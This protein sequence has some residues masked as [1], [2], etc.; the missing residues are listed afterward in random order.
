MKLTCSSSFQSKM[1]GTGQRLG[2]DQNGWPE[3]VTESLGKLYNSCWI[4]LVNRFSNSR[5]AQMIH[6]SKTSG[7]A[8]TRKLCRVCRI[9][10][11]FPELLSV[12]SR[13][14]GCER[15]KLT[16]SAGFWKSSSNFSFA[17]YEY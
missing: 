17:H 6:S 15:Y 14:F 3:E 4:S 9:S 8:V 1:T 16:F 12:D 11:W 2:P 13:K 10:S 7:R 5:R